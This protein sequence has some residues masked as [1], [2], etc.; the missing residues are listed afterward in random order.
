MVSAGDHVTAR[1]VAEQNVRELVE[2]AREGYSIVCTEPSAALCLKQEYPML[3]SHPDVDLVADQVVEAGTYLRGLHRENRLKT[4][5]SPLN[6][7]V[8]YHTPC[9]VKALGQ[10]TPLRDLLSLIPE[11]RVRTIEKGCSG[12]A[13]AWG[14][15]RANFSKSIQIG[16][17][18][19]SHM[20]EQPMDIGA[21][22]CCSCKIQMEQG[23]TKPTLHPLK[24]LALSY[25]LM[26]ELE[27]KLSPSKRK[28][29]VS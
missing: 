5:F 6:L 21:T 20:R 11:L 18:L 1:D 13:G 9:H 8:A 14:L 7:T 23:T 29:V 25:G 26:P 16:W 2:L 17:E 22:E 15:T 12:M 28:L 3:I 10:G 27:R 24:L 4:D 19:I